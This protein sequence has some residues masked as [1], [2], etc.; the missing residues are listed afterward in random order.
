MIWQYFPHFAFVALLTWSAGAYFSWKT[1]R[2]PTLILTGLGLAVFLSYIIMMWVMLERPPLRTMGETRL[3]YVLFLPATGL[4]VYVRWRFRWIL[5][6]STIMSA[7]FIGIN[8][9]KPEIHDKTLMPA[10]QSP[11]FAPHVIVYM[12]AYALLGAATLMAVYNLWKGKQ[13]MDENVALTNLVYIGWAFLTVGM[14]FGALWAKEAWGHYWSWDPKETWA[15]VTWMAYLVY[16]HLSSDRIKVS[17][18]K[19]TVLRNLSLIWL[20]ICFA[21]LQMCWWGINLLPSAQATSIHTYS[22]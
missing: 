9:L 1:R 11:W 4:L 10:L 7:V 2:T 8:L 19:Q 17:N 16:I 20:I 13:A 22:G 15:A 14:L 21:L 6:F 18:D 3:W 5:P 12:F